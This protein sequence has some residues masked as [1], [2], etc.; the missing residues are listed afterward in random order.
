LTRAAIDRMY[1]AEGIPVLIMWGERDPIIPVRHG[2][3]AHE[4]IPG[5]RLEIFECVGHL[6]QLEAPAKFV[7]TLERF[8]ED[9]EPAQ[10]DSDAWRSRLRSTAAYPR[11]ER[12]PRRAAG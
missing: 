5:S 12:P 3:R 11:A 9:S 6:P 1:L 7:A 2:R 8:L 10:F 4:A